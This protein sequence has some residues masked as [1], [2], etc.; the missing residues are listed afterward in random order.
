MIASEIRKGLVKAFLKPIW[1]IFVQPFVS[2]T[3]GTKVLYRIIMGRSLNLTQPKDINEKIQWLKLN[4]KHPL[5]AQ[6]ADKYGV[7]EYI[8][9]QG[10][11]DVLNELYGVYDRV[12]DI[13]WDLLPE[14]FALKCTHGCGY[15][16]ICNDKAK[17]NR[18]FARIRLEWWMRSSY[19]RRHAEYHYI[20]I[21]PRIICERY[22]ETPEAILPND[23]K[24][25]CF[26][27]RPHFVAVATDRGTRVKWHFLD[28]DWNRMDIALS[29]HTQ[30]NLPVKPV[31]WDHM[32]EVAVKLSQSFPFV[33]V[34]FYEEN[35][36]AVFGEMTFTPGAGMLRGYYNEAGMKF[37]G[38]L[39]YLPQD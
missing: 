29:E 27:G 7:R 21:K 10:C 26:H 37:L 15:N 23:Y 33:R 6:C 8:A 18:L 35:G 38:E 20:S 9:E 34:D 5:L 39:L 31:C 2:Q 28:M 14:K 12:T 30:G 24:M 25:Y 17:L 3:V 36:R 1:R 32:R 4:W 22:I 13:P 19:G 11:S 16:I